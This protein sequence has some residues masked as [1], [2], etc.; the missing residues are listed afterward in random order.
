MSSIPYEDQ[1]LSAT[2]APWLAPAPHRGKKN[3]PAFVAD[4]AGY[5]AELLELD[6]AVLAELTRANFFSL[7]RLAR[8]AVD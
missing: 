1:T 5:L 3:E 7:F 8:D 6:C 2:D 4:T